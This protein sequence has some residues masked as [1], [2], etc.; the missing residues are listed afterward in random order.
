MVGPK[1]TLE[2]QNVAP[3]VHL[4]SN[5]TTIAEA[6]LGLSIADRAWI[7]TQIIDS[8][9]CDGVREEDIFSLA[10]ERDA[11]IESGVVSELTHDEFLRGLRHRPDEA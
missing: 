7:A 8:M 9:S 11:E 3:I 4:M 2:K 5:A 6:A 1:N 10:T